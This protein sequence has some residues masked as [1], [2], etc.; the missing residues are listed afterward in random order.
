MA[1]ISTAQPDSAGTKMAVEMRRYAAKDKPSIGSSSVTTRY[2][3]GGN[4]RSTPFKQKGL[5]NVTVLVVVRVIKQTRDG[6][7]AM[8]GYRA[9]TAPRAICDLMGSAVSAV[10]RVD[11]VRTSSACAVNTPN[12]FRQK[13]A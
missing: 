2:S 11:K 9:L 13:D 12:C 7:V 8:L 10:T 6:S 5:W 1:T 4:I 3:A